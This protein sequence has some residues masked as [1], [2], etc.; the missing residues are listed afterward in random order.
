MQT[1]A[2]AGILFVSVLMLVSA[3]AAEDASGWYVKGQNAAATGDYTTALTYYNNAISLD[4]SYAPSYIG[5]AVALNALG[6]YSEGLDAANRA[7]SIR[8][9]SDAWN[10]RANAFFGLGRYSE[11]KSAYT[12]YTSSVTNN[13]SAYCNLGYSSAQI[14]DTPSAITAYTRCTSLDP[15]NAGAW[16]R[17][18][19]VYMSAGEHSDA[20][21]AFN[22]A[23]RL[24]VNDAAIWNN[25]G[26]A[27]AALGRYQD[28]LSCYNKALSIDPA[29]T[30]A[31]KNKADAL[32]KA[33]VYQVT[34]SPTPTE[35]PWVLGGVKTTTVATVVTTGA[36][37]ASPAI[38]AETTPV[39]S[40]TLAAVD[41][42][43]P[44]AAKTTFTPLSPWSAVLAFGVVTG[45]LA[46][47][48]RMKE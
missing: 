10:A 33:Q 37:V 28:A 14:G 31:L 22:S 32:G 12:N 11:A 9:S 15:L 24:T 5:K 41:T 20:L 21:D 36:A 4:S 29:N 42:G 39:G 35:A 40:G 48:R 16:N 7:L 23:T 25:K 44:V 3:V 38:P 1:S 46:F 6:R 34:G 17:L 27:L 47:C 19:L 18:G 43:T 2:K 26:L 30:D 8:A 45:M 13:A